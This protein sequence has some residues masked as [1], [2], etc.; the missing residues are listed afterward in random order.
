MEAR[1]KVYAQ[2]IEILA[3]DVPTLILFD[4]IGIDAARGKLRNL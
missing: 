3:R 4:E 1:A 2:V